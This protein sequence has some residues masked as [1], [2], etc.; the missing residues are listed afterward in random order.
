MHCGQPSYVVHADKDTVIDNCWETT[1][2]TLLI[3]KL[4]LWMQ[5]A[6]RS[7]NE[8]YYQLLLTA[9]ISYYL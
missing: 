5:G 9:I 6:E 7:V 2:L 3:P 1:V 8:L 4:L